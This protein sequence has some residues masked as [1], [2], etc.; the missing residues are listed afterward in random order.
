MYIF[1]QHR[2]VVLAGLILLP[3]LAWAHDGHTHDE[4]PAAVGT[5]LPRFTAVSEAFELVGVLDGRRLTLYL[6]RASDNRPVSGARITLEIDGRK[7]VVKA[8]EQDAAVYEALL[9]ETLPLGLL[10]VTAEVTAGS[11]HDLLAGE[12]DLHGVALEEHTGLRWRVVLGAGAALLLA[13]L[14]FMYTRL[15][16]RKL[17]PGGVA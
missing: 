3:A 2:L 14:V 10:S 4:A 12:L 16:V 13:G 11:E 6:D 17:R 5:A 15:R 1:S 9:D 8:T 7:P